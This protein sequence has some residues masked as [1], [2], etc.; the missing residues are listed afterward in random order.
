M[1]VVVASESGQV[2][3]YAMLDGGAANS[4]VSKSLAKSLKLE[5]KERDST[6]IVVGGSSREKRQFGDVAIA[7]LEGNLVINVKEAVVMDILTTEEDKPPS[8]DEIKDVDYLEDVS[9]DEL[10]EKTVGMLIGMRHAWTWLG[11]EVRRSTPDKPLALKTRFGWALAGGCDRDGTGEMSCYKISIQKDNEDI[12]E[13]VEK[14]FRQDFPNI[15]F[16]EKHM[17]R[18]D[19]YAMKQMEETIRFDEEIGHYRVGLPWKTSRAEAAKKLNGINSSKSAL[20]R[21][22]KSIK[23]VKEDK[24]YFEPGKYFEYAKAQMNAMFEDGHVEILERHEISD[25]FPTWVMPLNI[26]YQPHKPTKP[27]CCHDGKAKTGGRV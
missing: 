13:C 6:L 18:D 8:N 1:P 23:R 10:E 9:F 3:T 25:D 15:P 24:K 26:V 7:N 5:T 14:L 27:R 20:S 19:E 11:G 2:R 17:S 12:H 4:V 16:N 22:K 21:L